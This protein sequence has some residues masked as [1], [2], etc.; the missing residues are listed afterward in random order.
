LRRSLPVLQWTTETNN[1]EIREKENIH[2]V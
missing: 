2:T 1:G